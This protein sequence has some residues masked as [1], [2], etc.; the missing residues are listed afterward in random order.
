MFLI[1]IFHVNLMMIIRENNWIVFHRGNLK[2]AG[3]YYF[4]FSNFWKSLDPNVAGMFL[5]ATPTGTFTAVACSASTTTPPWTCSSSISAMWASSIL[6]S[7]SRW[8]SRTWTHRS[9]QSRVASSPGPRLTTRRSSFTRIPRDLS[10]SVRPSPLT[11][12][13]FSLRS[14]SRPG[15]P[16]PVNKGAPFHRDCANVRL[17]LPARF[18]ALYV[19]EI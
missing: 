11:P 2:Y 15:E 7:S 3:H 4:S 5:C 18:A 19:A 12:K 8:T 1:I 10:S 9:V 14:S 17:R 6:P 13:K 16:D